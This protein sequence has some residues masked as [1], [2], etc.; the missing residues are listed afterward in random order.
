MIRLLQEDRVSSQWYKRFQGFGGVT[1]ATALSRLQ[2]STFQTVRKSSKMLTEFKLVSARRRKPIG[3]IRFERVDPAHVEEWTQAAV[4]A[5]IDE[6][7]AKRDAASRKQAA[8]RETAIA[9][10]MSEEQRV[11]S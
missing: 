10:D 8:Q 6:H 11:C 2:V 3:S 4:P 5:E 7:L 1:R 9:Q